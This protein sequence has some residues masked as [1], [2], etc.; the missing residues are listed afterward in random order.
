MI[1]CDT[2][3]LIAWVDSGQGETH[4]RCR[5]FL[6]GLHDSLI[7]TW[8]SVTEAM[9]LAHRIGGWPMLADTAFALAVAGHKRVRHPFRPPRR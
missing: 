7:T 6:D 8:P 9:Y 5:A 2:G 3:P 1:L 4:D